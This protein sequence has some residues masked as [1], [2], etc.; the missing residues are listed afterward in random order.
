MK[1]SR[2][3]KKFENTLRSANATFEFRFFKIKFVFVALFQGPD[4]YISGVK[5]FSIF[6]DFFPSALFLRK[7]KVSY[8]DSQISL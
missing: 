1:N 8:D 6:N 2:K 4:T 3:S 5:P 7:S